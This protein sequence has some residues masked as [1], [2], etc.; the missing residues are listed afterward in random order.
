MQPQRTSRS[1]YV[2]I[3]LVLLCWAMVGVAVFGRHAVFDWWRLRNYTP[4]ATVA[5]LATDTTMNSSA[6]NLFYA[7]HPVVEG[8]D[9]FNSHCRDNEFTIVLGCYI[10]YKG[11][12]IFD[13]DDPRLEGVQQVTAAHELLHAAYDRLSSA[14]KERIDT[15]TAQV[16]NDIQDER[17]RKTIE[18]YRSA[19]PASVPNEL[20]SILA[21]E[22]RKLPEELEDHYA[23]YFTDRS[24]IVSYSEK[25]E[26]VFSSRT[27]Q[28]ESL[29]RE[30]DDLK[31]KITY[32]NRELA[33]RGD[34]LNEQGDWIQE[35]ATSGQ[36]SQAEVD[37]FNQQVEEYNAELGQINRLIKSYNAKL[38][39]YN[40]LV[41][42]QEALMKELDSR[43]AAQ[44]SR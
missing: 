10:Q 43:P 44:T 31:S 3:V 2:A 41:G 26:A 18:E 36:A 20:H 11:I 37:S 14:E 9:A 32:G 24:K 22:V 29:R 28:I 42:E 13:I 25:Y 1:V 17:I 12:Y 6:R 5:Q 21:T 19:D 15:L 33:A 35:R 7:Y 38:K 34:Y 30:I 40:D 4:P 39:Q 27:T 23:R 16:Y 8:S